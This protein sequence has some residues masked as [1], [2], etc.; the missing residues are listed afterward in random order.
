MRKF[1]VVA[2][3]GGVL[4]VAQADERNPLSTRFIVDAGWFF[5]STDTRLRVNGETSDTVGSDVNFDDTFGVGDI[6]R[7]RGEVAWRFADRHVVRAMYFQNNRSGTRTLDEDV[8][9]RGETFPLNA[10]V[11]AV[12]ELSIAQLSYDYAFLH[13]PTYEVAAGIGIHYIDMAFKL[14]GEIT[15]P[16]GTITGTRQASAT[17]GA[18]LP[19]VGL[20]ALWRFAPRWYLTGQA[21]YFHLDFDPYEGSLIDLKA[22]L[23]WQF[24]DHVGAGVAYND[25]AFRV[26]VD[27][28]SRFNGQLRWDY[29]GAVAFVSVMF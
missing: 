3:L 17:T 1:V 28:E 26:D 21:Q 12:S 19:V 8:T 29:G 23:V 7:F 11:T 14:S 10:S 25:F 6:D 22:S 9:F 5:V 13:K 4:G 15:A 20:R 2:V 16:G 18:P 24:T 27:N